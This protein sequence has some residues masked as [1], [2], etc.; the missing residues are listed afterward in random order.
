MGKFKK[1]IQ[2]TAGIVISVVFLY[3]AFRRVNI[4]ETLQVIARVRWQFLIIA[5]AATIT[6]IYVRSYRWRIILN[7][8]LPLSYFVESTFVGQF[9]NNVLP[10][11]MGDLAQAYFLANK[12]NLSKSTAFSTVILERLTDVMPPVLILILGSFFVFMPEQIG[13][14]NILIVVAILFSILFCVI[15]FQK[16]LVGI[17]EKL[18][19]NSSFGKR[20]HQFIDN[21]YAGMSFVKDR[22]RFAKVA[23]L[24]ILLWGVYGFTAYCCLLAFNIHINYLGAM[25]VISVVAISVTIPASPGY[26]GTWEFFSILALSIFKVGK[27]VALSFALLYHLVGWLPVTLLGFIIVLKSG[28]SISKLENQEKTNM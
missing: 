21:F 18:L 2:I 17:F 6:G 1:P 26:V 25:L 7:K 15:K 10:F 5:V 9:I 14:F 8:D 22:K 28:I 27:S 4:Q 23:A 13:R 12:G 11:R 16:K 24:S 3:L 20:L 19:P